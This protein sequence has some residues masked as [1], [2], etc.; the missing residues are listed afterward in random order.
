MTAKPGIGGEELRRHLTALEAASDL[1]AERFDEAADSAR[2]IAQALRRTGDESGRQEL[3]EAAG[4]VIAASEIEL[5][6]RLQTLIACTRDEIESVLAPHG[7]VLVVED[8]PLPAKLLGQA[9][10]QKGWQVA[11]AGTAAQAKD[12]LETQPV[13]VIILDLVLPD[14]DGRNLLL[15]LK[16]DPRSSSLPVYIA[17][18]RSDPHVRAECLALGAEDFLQKPVD[19]DQILDALAQ[20][21]TPLAELQPQPELEFQGQLTDRGS[22][23]RGFEAGSSEKSFLALAAADKPEVAPTDA[24]ERIAMALVSAV[25]ERGT[26]ARWNADHVA[27]LIRADGMEEARQVMSEAQ[28]NL[29]ATGQLEI[30]LSAGVVAVESEATLD[31]VVHEAGRLLYLAQTAPG[32]RIVCDAQEVA[33]PST[34]I[35]LAEDDEVAAKLLVYRL[36]R[37]PGFEVTH[38]ADGNDTME[39]AEE[40]RF[41][42]LILDVNMPGMNGFDVLARLRERPEYQSVPIVMLTALGSEKDVVHGFELGANDYVA[43]PFSPLELIAR[44]RRLLG[45]AARAG[46]H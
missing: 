44:V 33:T 40:Q 42:L 12:I 23:V 35:L 36:T 28:Q 30:G 14:A 41:D 6:A 15:R 1:L 13:A 25:G 32:P 10:A 16:E 2:R 7:T 37:E 38:R 3:C 26:T 39:A 19:A 21:P 45:L 9:L 34:K 24:Q 4:G 29:A 17:S 11:V 20:R 31:D 8:D 22:L 5:P 27:V 18:S 43:K 46:A